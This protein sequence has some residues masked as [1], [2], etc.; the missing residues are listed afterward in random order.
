[1]NSRQIVMRES[2]AALRTSASKQ[3]MSIQQLLLI[4]L[5]MLRTKLCHIEG[6]PLQGYELRSKLC[7]ASPTA[8]ELE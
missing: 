7:M 6:T 8:N 1:M 3:G 2:I 5:P 4:M